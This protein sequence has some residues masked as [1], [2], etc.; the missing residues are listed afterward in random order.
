MEGGW[1]GEE[2]KKWVKREREREKWVGEG[3]KKGGGI[4]EIEKG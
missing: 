3:K 4:E 2:E 1:K